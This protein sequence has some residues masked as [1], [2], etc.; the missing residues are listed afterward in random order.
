MKLIEKKY[1]EEKNI[2]KSNEKKIEKLK[3]KLNK[4]EEKTK[5]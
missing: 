3:K 2:T 1:E 4:L 5:K